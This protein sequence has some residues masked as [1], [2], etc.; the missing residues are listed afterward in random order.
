MK[1]NMKR[2]AAF[3]GEDGGLPTAAPTN[4]T[5]ADRIA[6]TGSDFP[7]VPAKN[8]L[9]KSNIRRR[10]TATLINNKVIET[11]QKKGK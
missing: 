7:V 2:F 4:V 1:R 5:G 10:K 6:G 11:V 3:L 8:K 9:N